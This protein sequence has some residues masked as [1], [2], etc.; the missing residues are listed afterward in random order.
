[1][2]HVYDEQKNPRKRQKVNYMSKPRNLINRSSLTEIISIHELIQQ[3]DPN[4][5]RKKITITGKE[6]NIDECLDDFYYVA[7]TIQHI[8]QVILDDDMENIIR[9]LYDAEGKRLTQQANSLGRT[10]GYTPGNVLGINLWEETDL[11]EELS[12]KSR[13]DRFVAASVITSARGTDTRKTKW[14]SKINNLLYGTEVVKMSAGDSRT[15][16]PNPTKPGKVLDFSIVDKAYAKFVSKTRTTL[17]Y[18]VVC[19]NRWVRIVFAIPKHLQEAQF[20]AAPK[21]AWNN[22]HELSVVVTGQWE[23]QRYKLSDR[24]IIGI[25]VG[26]VHYVTYAVYDMI[27]NKI[28]ETGR[29]SNTIGKEMSVREKKIRTQINNMYEKII[30]LKQPNI[31]GYISEKN[32]EKIEHL[33]EEIARQRK[34]L[35]RLRKEKAILASNELSAISI[36]Y[37]NAALAHENLTWVAN[38]MQ[39]GRWNCGELFSRI[40]DKFEKCGGH[41]VWVNA[42]YTSQTCFNC[43]NKSLKINEEG[44]DFYQLPNSRFMFCEACETTID[45]D[46]NACGNIATRA[47]ELIK[48]L[49]TS[50]AKSATEYTKQ[51]EIK[52]AKK[53]YV[54]Q[55]IRKQQSEKDKN[56]KKDKDRTKNTPTPK[57]YE[58]NKRRKHGYRIPSELREILRLK[59]VKKKSLRLLYPS[60][61]NGIR[62][63]QYFNSVVGEAKASVLANISNDIS[64]WFANKNERTVCTSYL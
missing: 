32:I 23:K 17:T 60:C 9:N 22:K 44:K 58:A 15:V 31:F 2:I 64:E 14:E 10:L 48:K 62:G 47:V 40:N 21:L 7:D 46:E 18:D 54:P 24:Y 25:D 56:K 61:F 8:S 12:N 26:I 34:G 6:L 35:S 51:P 1:M 3:P 20:F 11:S 27:E 16:R 4:D 55:Y 30:K 53:S 29:L 42:A 33:A 57:R 43:G 45:R 13:V 63:P 38:T 36:R 28:V 59:E 41:T 19:K 50:R 49:N 5:L 39:H 37:G 52:V